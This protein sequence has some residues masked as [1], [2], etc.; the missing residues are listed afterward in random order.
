MFRCPFA[1][2]PA[3]PRLTF[4]IICYKSLVDPCNGV[5][6]AWHLDLHKLAIFC[7]SL[8]GPLLPGQIRIPSLA[9]SF[10]EE[11]VHPPDFCYGF[12]IKFPRGNPAHASPDAPRPPLWTGF[13]LATTSRSRTN[14]FSAFLAASPF[15]GSCRSVL[16]AARS[17]IAF[18]DLP[19]R[20]FQERPVLNRS[21]RP[22]K[23][24]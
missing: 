21:Q 12:A 17:C 9:P 14:Y 16:I 15:G 7:M 6:V 22:I 20:R 4:A 5:Q 23:D 1:M 11:S 8:H 19:T 24:L 10:P 3:S 13:S 18:P 2:K